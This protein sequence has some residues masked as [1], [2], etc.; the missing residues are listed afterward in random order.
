VWVANGGVIGI[1]TSAT[2]SYKSTFGAPNSPPHGFVN[3]MV[4]VVYD[5]VNDIVRSSVL[6]V[7][8]YIL[9]AD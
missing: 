9:M 2:G 5:T 7:Y 6:Q 8:G 1:I 4:S 3:E